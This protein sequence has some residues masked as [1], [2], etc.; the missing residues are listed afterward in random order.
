MEFCRDKKTEQSLRRFGTFARIKT[1]NSPM[2]NIILI[3]LLILL[4][5]THGFAQSIDFR[6]QVS[7]W[8][9]V[10]GKQLEKSQLG[11][12]Y[13]P[14]LIFEKSLAKGL[15]INT[16]ISINSYGSGQ[17]NG[18]NNMETNGK[19]KPYRLWLRLASS[20]FEVRLGL[21]KINFGSAS[22]L[23]PL[24]WFDRIDP[25]DPLQMT[26]G[27][28]AVLGRYYFINNANIWLWALYGNDDKKGMEAFPSDKKKVEYGGRI[29]VP[30]LTGEI[31]L[32]YHH[33]QADLRKEPLAGFISTKNSIPEDRLG[34]DC[35]W[36]IG[37]GLWFEGALIHQDVLIK[38]LQYQRLSTIGL[39]Y[40]FPIGNGIYAMAE[41]FTLATSDEAFK[42]GESFSFS[43]AS[44][45]YPLN[46]VDNIMFMLYYSNDNKD[47][48]RF[49][50]WQ[51]IYDKWSCYFI[52][53]W[54]PEQFQIYP[55]MEGNKL[56]TGKGF[57]L[58]VVYNY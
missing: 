8:I 39:D 42:G 46:I 27:V 35:K 9:T 1:Q 55:N 11:I 31:G 57:Q 12:R 54:N 4:S 48:Y 14:E 15:T 38:Q 44:L 45:N 13:L 50:N 24:M 21:Q 7:G 16:D 3:N 41:Y 25:R 29:Q 6:G 47:W 5:L 26:D 49:I 30:L 51:R 18:W 19:I 32:T 52:G 20:Q 22:M 33:R 53:F 56:F 37:I 43:A 28:Y 34:F 2:K 17:F 58:M 10:N 23:R 36:D 40:T